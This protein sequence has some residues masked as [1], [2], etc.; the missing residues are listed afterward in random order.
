VTPVRLWTAADLPAD[1]LAALSATAFAE[2]GWSAARLA[3][4]V[5]TPGGI[6]LVDAGRDALVLMLAAGGE[7]EILDL[8][9]RPAARRRG[10]ARRLLAH[11]HDEAHRRGA[12]RAVLEVAEDNLPARALYDTLGYAEAGRRPRYYARP[13]G[14]ADALVLARALP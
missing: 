5:A 3:T 7:A 14:R 8:G 10:L 6:V 12:A 1:A 11:G 9:V 13:A 2:G 4:L